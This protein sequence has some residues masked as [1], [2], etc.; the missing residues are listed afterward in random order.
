[1][2]VK[3]VVHVRAAAGSV[4]ARSLRDG[5]ARIQSELKVSPD[6]PAEVEQAA[7]AAAGNPRL[8]DLDRSDIP[9][10]TIDPPGSMDLDQALHLERDGD[11]YRVHYAI[12]DVAAF[13]APGDPVDLEAQRRGETLYG[14]DSK[15]PLH[16]KVL[17]ED[18][19]S[20]L[21]DQLR[22][23]LLWTIACDETGEGTDVSVVRA[24]VRS[25]ARLDYEGAQRSIDDGSADESLRLLAELGPLRLR[26]EAER[27]G[28]SLPLPEQQVDVSDDHW[29][30]EFR[31]LLPVEEWNAQMSLLTGFGAASLML[32]AR[33]GLLRTL[34]PPDPR[35]V[36]RLHRTALAL[37]I[38]WPA[39]QPY[40]EFIRSLDPTEPA[41]AA[42]VTACTRL[43]RGS[44]YA[45]FNGEVPADPR[46]AALASEYAHVTA[47]LRRLGDRFASEVCVALCADAEVPAWVREKL[48]E[49]PGMLQDSGR[50]ARQ[51]E[52]GVLDLVEAGV[53]KDR[54]GETFAAVVVD[55]DE[56]DA[57]RGVI[58][59]RDPAVEAP[60]RS[61]TALPLGTEVP[62]RLTLA[63]LATRKVAFT[64]EQG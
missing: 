12:A 1:M 25:R 17:S 42:M 41:H 62:V 39:G 46:H 50:R 49:L 59:L 55:V 56:K 10:V 52:S 3:R 7:A 51:Y 33:V 13:V 11:G 16:P 8:P 29:R 36:E 22:P 53:L 48:A 31:S 24:L 21:P 43:L 63:D 61:A 15:V 28:V 34:P 44:G 6:F 47:P 26:R 40:P 18:A 37:H 19:A 14:A 58:T 23:A 45:G 32:G 54:V 64:F 9:F 27:G 5:I 35:D 30:L 20:L 60:V 57:T 4:A 2:P 38:E